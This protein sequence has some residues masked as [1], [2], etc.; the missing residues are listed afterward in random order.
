MTKEM[1]LTIAR[2]Y[3]AGKSCLW[4]ARL[5]NALLQEHTVS[6]SFSKRT[7][8]TEKEL[9]IQRKAYMSTILN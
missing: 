5:A 7:M 8:P 3:I 4:A 1:A 2:T 6:F 9:A